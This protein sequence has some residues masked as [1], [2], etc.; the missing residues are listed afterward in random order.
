MTF[1]AQSGNNK[2][3][4][5][6]IPANFA[7]A[8]ETVQYYFKIPY[9]DHLPTFLYGDD[10]GWNTSELESVAQANPFSYT[11]KAQ[12]ALVTPSPADWRDLNIY[13][14]LTDR[15]FDGDPANNTANPYGTFDPGSGGA[16]HGG[17]FKG[18]QQKLDYVKALGANA[19][20]ISPV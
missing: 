2:Y 4:M 3:Y 10:A 15:F 17:D 7:A 19:I 6:G 9:S 14:I 8:G 12:P 16:I 13:Q 5:S 18:I 1:Y 11:V 20:W